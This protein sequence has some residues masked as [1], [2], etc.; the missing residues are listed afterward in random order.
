LWIGKIK[1]KAESVW[2]PEFADFLAEHLKEFIPITLKVFF[3]GREIEMLVV[4]SLGIPQ[5]LQALSDP[6]GQA[7][8]CQLLLGITFSEIA[9]IESP[10]NA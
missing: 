2:V 7:P 10:A 5:A 4:I 6:V 1:V 9:V 8:A 3:G